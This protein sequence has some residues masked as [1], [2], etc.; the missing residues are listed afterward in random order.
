MRAARTRHGDDGGGILTWLP[1]VPTGVE[2]CQPFHVEVPDLR[3]VASPSADAVAVAVAVAIAAEITEKKEG[4]T[5]DEVM[6]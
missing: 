5:L 6:L 4:R 2:G 3:R 1:Q